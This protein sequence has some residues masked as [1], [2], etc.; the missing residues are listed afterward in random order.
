MLTSKLDPVMP[1]SN[2]KRLLSYVFYRSGLKIALAHF[3][4]L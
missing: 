3:W 1:G 4:V 2:D